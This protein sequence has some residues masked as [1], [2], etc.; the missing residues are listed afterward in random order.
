MI[1][2]P[3]TIKNYAPTANT[4]ATPAEDTAVTF[5]VPANVDLNG[6]TLTITNTTAVSNGVLVSNGNGSFTYTPAFDFNGGDS[7]TYITRWQGGATTATVIYGDGSQRRL[8]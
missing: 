3:G 6:D 8:R 5:N 7:F 4:D 2:S 1:G